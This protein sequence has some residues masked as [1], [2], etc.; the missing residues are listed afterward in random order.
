[1]A[2]KIIPSIG[3]LNTYVNPLVKDD[4][5]LIRAVNVTSDQYGAKTKRSGYS[6]YLG[7]AD[8]SAVTTLFSF[9]KNDKSDFWNYRASGTNLYYSYRGLSEWTACT[10][11]SISAG[12]TV[13]YAV[14]D[15]TMIICDGVNP[16]RHTT[17]GVTF[18]DTTLAPVAVSLA[19]YQNRIYAAGTASDLFYSTSGNAADWATSGTSDS[20]SF[21]IPGAGKLN[22]V[23]TANDKIVA[24]KNSGAMF[25]WDGYALIDMA[26]DLGP[27]SA[28]SY[29]RVE[30]YSMWM[31]RLGVFG[32]GGGR[33]E[34]LSNSVRNQIYNTA[35]SGIA[36]TVF[37]TLPG[38][39]YRYDY[40]AAIGDTTDSFTNETVSNAILK[41]D[42]SQNEWLNWKFY[43]FPT[44]LCSYQDY[45]GVDQLIWGDANGQCYQLSGTATDDNGQAIESVMEFLTFFSTFDDEK[46]WEW[47]N[48]STNPGCE[49]KVAVA[50][51][52]TYTHSHLKWT[53]IGDCS[54]GF[55]RFRLPQNSRSRL[56][57]I[58]LYESSLSSPYTLYGL[59]IEAKIV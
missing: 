44:A 40:L 17:D 47:L 41:Y 38:A 14:L 9:Y 39:I 26:T 25:K 10:N 1:M 30:D 11:G 45:W 27:T 52:D 33:P 29:A 15:N 13:S 34:M 20:S 53:E 55:N 5:Q 36:G 7:T 4:S 6:T 48:I 23:F 56:M 51:S 18:T 46:K 8:G 57:F 37:N 35:G 59:S 24:C 22:K 2:K 19:M 43:N 28:A 49:L 31:N 42:F 16:T 3:G 21:V 58:K 54:N 50:F 12:A 32:Y